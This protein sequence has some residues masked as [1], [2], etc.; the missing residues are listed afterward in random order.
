MSERLAIGTKLR[1][2][3]F[4]RDGATCVKC[5]RKRKLEVHH[6]IPVI[7]GGTN[8]AENLITLCRECHKAAPDEPAQF[9]RW[10]ASGLP[11][12]MDLSRHLTKVCVSILYH[13]CGETEA[14]VEAALAMVDEIY[15]DLW[16]VCRG[17]T[18]DFE[19]RL[20]WAAMEQFWRKYYPDEARRRDEERRA[21]EQG[22]TQQQPHC[23]EGAGPEQEPPNKPMKLTGVRGRP[24]AA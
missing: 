13:R 7:Y 1:K 23:P 10:A 16:Q 19:D 5:R 4:T 20:G 18:A 9:F 6:V 11:P 2:E 22:R 21:I 14:N 3:V 17:L 12:K 15:P 24:P 8:V